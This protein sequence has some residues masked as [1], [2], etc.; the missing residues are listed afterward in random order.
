MKYDETLE[1]MARRTGC[2][3]A[4]A[5]AFFDEF[6]DLLHTG[7]EV[8]LPKLGEFKVVQRKARSGTDPHGNEWTKPAHGAPRFKAF[9]A[10]REAVE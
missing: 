10:Y 2:T 1:E 7:V 9:T 8:N 4:Q 6:R 5:D 3:K